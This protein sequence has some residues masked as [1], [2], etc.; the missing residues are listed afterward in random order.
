MTKDSRDLE[1]LVQKI[2]K[3]LAPDAEVL[4]DVT[5]PG[6]DGKRKRQIDVLVRQKIGQYEMLIVL[7][8][9]DHARPV[10]V[11][12]VGAFHTLVTDVGANRG[13]LVCPRGFTSG[14][15]TLATDLQID[16]FSPVDTDPHKWQ[17]HVTVPVVCD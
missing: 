10:D 3:Q 6:K 9:K 7:D 5:L 12:G 8:C 15:K 17:A 1:I 4:H 14:A 11:N 13:A 16:L 2:Q